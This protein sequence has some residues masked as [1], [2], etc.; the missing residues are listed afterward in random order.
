MLSIFLAAVAALAADTPSE[1]GQGALPQVSK[2]RHETRD[3][4]GEVCA[5]AETFYRG[6]E[7]ILI[8]ATYTK[9][10]PSGIK[11][12]REYMVGGTVLKEMDYGAAKPQIIWVF[13]NGAVHEGFRRHPDGSVEPMTGEELAKAKSEAGEFMAGFEQV[14]EKVRER[15]QTNSVEKVMRD[16]KTEVDQYKQQQKPGA[17]AK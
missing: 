13:Q 14:M 10:Q 17:D 8:Q 11:M 2:K 16:L 5:Y 1:H 4:S 6:G 9:P 3:A 12:W 7:R 15:I